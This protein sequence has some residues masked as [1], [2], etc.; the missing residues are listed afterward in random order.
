MA[1]IEQ[2][3][4]SYRQELIQ[5][6]EAIE[7]TEQRY[8]AFLQDLTLKAASSIYSDFNKANSLRPFWKNYEP[9]QRGRS[10]TGNSTP[11][12]E[13]AEKTVTVHIIS[14]LT[15]ENLA[16]LEYPGLPL[17]SDVR[18]VINDVLIQLDVKATGPNDNQNE[19]VA[20]PFQISGDG[21][22]WQGD[23]FLNS[24]VS[25]PRRGKTKEPMLFRPALP[26]FYILEKHRLLC[27]TYFLKVNY[28][29][30]LGGDQILD[31]LELICVPNGLLL[32]DGPKYHQNTPGLLIAG[33]DDKSVLT[34]NRR[35]RI[36]F[37]PLATIGGWSRC[38]QIK[39]ADIGWKAIPRTVTSIQLAMEQQV[40]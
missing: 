31:Y 3:F 17:G 25:V 34:G 18:F 30:H 23:G 19:V 11:W 27:L 13:V 33:K 14:T 1:S 9:R 28:S 6:P 8:M 37:N 29:R 4:Q 35:T 10:P 16:T 40:E 26:P 22:L 38:V 32:F 15:R 39:Q 2:E 21:A 24:E 12:I 20:S 36:R 7:A 5:Q